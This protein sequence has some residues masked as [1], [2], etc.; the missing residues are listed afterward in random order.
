LTASGVAAG[1]LVDTGSAAE[2]VS[3]VAPIINI[4]MM[5]FML[6][7]SP[8]ALMGIFCCCFVPI[9]RALMQ[10]IMQN[11]CQTRRNRFFIKK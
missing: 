2:T 1:A 8:L 11:L 4:P 7:L 6:S 9:T 3:A 10:V 5:F